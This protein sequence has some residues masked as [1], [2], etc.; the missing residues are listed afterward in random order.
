MTRTLFAA[1][2][3]LSL[4]FAAH[5]S[6]MT[7][8]YSFCQK[9]NCKDGDQPSSPV[10]IDSAGNLY[11]TTLDG[12]TID[13]GVVYELTFDSQSKKWVETVLTN[14]SSAGGGG[15]KPY[16]P[17]IIDH[18]GN[19]YGTASATAF[20]V[21]NGAGLV[22]ELVKS[23]GWKKQTLY[24]FCAQA[25]CAD[26][27]APS[28]GVTY[29]GQSSGVPYDGVSPLYGT[30][31]AGGTKDYGVVFKLT[32]SKGKWTETVLHSFCQVNDCKDGKNTS[33]VVAD[34]S[35]LLWGTAQTV[36]PSILYK[37]SA[38]NG[39]QEVVWN[40]CTKRNCADGDG[41]GG[42]IL[43]AAGHIFGTDGFKGKKN[44]GV[45]YEMAGSKKLKFNILHNFCSLQNCTD[46]ENSTSLVM[47]GSGN[48]FGVTLGGGTENAGT[49][50]KLTGKKFTQLYDFCGAQDSCSKGYYPDNYNPT[51]DGNGNLYGATTRGGNNDK[52]TVYMLTP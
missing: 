23:Q 10:L 40:F 18:A 29:V 5:A 49:I 19:I 51:L 1:A 6:T 3:I 47:D 36:G 13:Y 37:M 25:G 52:G 11:G 46:G 14:F 34:G 12:G 7:A 2:A 16:G 33:P 35:G 50:F 22:Y 21:N 31:A 45:I 32:P 28:T 39:A 30:T 27:D 20:N 4:A 41:A 48:L 43:D 9:E 8:L 38:A 26:G 15:Y 24:T 44:H 42:I 17:L